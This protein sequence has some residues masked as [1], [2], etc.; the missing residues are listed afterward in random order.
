MSQTE[1]NRTASGAYREA[2]HTLHRQTVTFR[3]PYYFTPHAQLS[4][5]SGM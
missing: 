4:F 5:H 1:M 3:I 2:M